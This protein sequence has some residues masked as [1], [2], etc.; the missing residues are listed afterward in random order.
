MATA[1]QH[2]YIPQFYLKGFAKKPH[3]TAKLYVFDMHKGAWLPH[4]TNPK[5]IGTVRDFNRINAK[6]YPP[7]ALE[8][9]LS[10]FETE[11][12]KVVRNICEKKELPI[13]EEWLCIANLI[14]LLSVRNPRVREGHAD[15]VKQIAEQITALTLATKER[16]ESSVKEMKEA[17]FGADL[18]DVSYEEMLKFHEEKRYDIKVGNGLFIPAEFGALETVINT[19]LAR[20]WTL[21]VAGDLAG[22]FVCSDHPVRLRWSDPASDKFF[23]PG[24]AL[25]GT[26]V[27]FPLSKELVLIGTFEGSQGEII[28]DR[29]AIAMINTVII[30]GSGR[31]IFSPSND[32]EFYS[33]DGMVLNSSEVFRHFR[34]IDRKRPSRGR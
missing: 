28:A 26:E 17:G 2:H 7:D 33:T 20:K 3:K 18:P 34:R 22:H 24:H 25:A 31:Q 30:E 27:I 21:L 8:T 11:A 6:D 32:F 29:R 16:W 9:S 12:A 23:P 1:R 19:L 4:P 5:N 15:F 10:A 14:A 13:A